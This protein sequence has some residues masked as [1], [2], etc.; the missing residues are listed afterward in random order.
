MNLLLS[1]N[2]VKVVSSGSTTRALRLRAWLGK[3]RSHCPTSCLLHVLHLAIYHSTTSRL[4]DTFHSHTYTSILA[5]TQQCPKQKKRCR[6]R[7]CRKSL[8]VRRSLRCV[9]SSYLIRTSYHRDLDEPGKRTIHQR[10][11]VRKGDRRYLE[12]GLPRCVMSPSAFERRANRSLRIEFI[13]MISMQ[14]NEI[15]EKDKKKTIAPEHAIQA[16]SVSPFRHCQASVANALS[17]RLSAGI[18]M[19]RT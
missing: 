9:C 3:L 7:R 6:A 13:K 19:K 14:S 17:Y 2:N 8:R 15:C 1:L 4:T 11:L 12:L 16:I 18:S 10:V 5:A